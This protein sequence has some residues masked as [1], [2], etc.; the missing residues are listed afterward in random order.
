MGPAS[1]RPSTGIPVGIA[2][3]VRE[4]VRL[5]EIG[6]VIEEWQEVGANRLTEVEKKLS[7]TEE[8]EQLQKHA[9]NL[10]KS[11]DNKSV[12]QHE[13]Q[14]QERLLVQSEAR[15][16]EIDRTIEAWKEMAKAEDDPPSGTAAELAYISTQL[17]SGGFAQ[18]AKAALT[19]LTQKE[20]DIG[21]DADAHNAIKTQ[22]RKLVK[23]R[24]MYQELQRAEAAVKPLDDTLKG[25]GGGF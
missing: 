11:V 23:A 17:A 16:E 9:V 25:T 20:S 2:Y 21:Y 14:Q 19:K 24:E 4:L 7:D 12:L 5:E 8:F 13:L 10:R 15:L 6:R 1:R 18:D 22:W 3:G